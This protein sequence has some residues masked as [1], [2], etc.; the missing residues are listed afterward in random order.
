MAPWQCCLQNSQFLTAL[1]ELESLVPSMVTTRSS[2]LSSS[3][4]RTDALSLRHSQARL[5]AVSM[6]ACQA[7]GQLEFLNYQARTLSF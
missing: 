6:E 1:Y 3:S 4:A 5:P 2:R 7:V